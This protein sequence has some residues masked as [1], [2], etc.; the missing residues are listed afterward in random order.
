MMY[1]HV[2]NGAGTAGGFFRFGFF[3]VLVLDFSLFRFREVPQS[4]AKACA[5]GFGGPF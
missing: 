4:I 1:D 2:Y 5:G 3:E